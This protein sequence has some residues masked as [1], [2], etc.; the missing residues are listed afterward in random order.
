MP[1][2]SS[3]LDALP[4]AATEALTRLGEHLAIARARRKEPQRAWAKRLGVS[5]PTL[6]RMESGD[7]RVAMGVYATALWMIGRAQALPDLA[8]PQ[9][10]AGA[11]EGEL[12]AV[13]K[14]RAV[15]SPASVEARLRG[16]A[17]EKAVKNTKPVKRGK[18]GGDG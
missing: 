5:V 4:P 3:A 10:D 18:Q 7:P 14:R 2:V 16:A 1:R 15:R 9:N 12:R 13:M 8:A 11:L 17:A 6:I